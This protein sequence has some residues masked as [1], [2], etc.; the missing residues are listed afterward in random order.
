MSTFR[1][2]RNKRGKIPDCSDEIVETM[3]NPSGEESQAL[4]AQ[5]LMQPSGNPTSV[6]SGTVLLPLGIRMHAFT[7]ISHRG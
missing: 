7:H 5:H 6:R 4:E 2:I 1:V 3:R